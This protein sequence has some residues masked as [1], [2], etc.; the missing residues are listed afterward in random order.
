M[1]TYIYSSLLKKGA[2]KERKAEALFL[3]VCV[4]VLCVCCVYMYTSVSACTWID[5]TLSIYSLP[6]H[7]LLSTIKASV[8]SPHPWK[9]LCTTLPSIC[10]S[11]NASLPRKSC[12]PISSHDPFDHHVS[13]YSPFTPL[14]PYSAYTD[15]VPTVAQLHWSPLLRSGSA[16]STSLFFSHTHFFSCLEICTTTKKENLIDT[17]NSHSRNV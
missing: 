1:R 4:C 14:C 11:A 15:T 16:P 10:P 8:H 3:H 2:K 12:T 9:G 7:K 13:A 17:F 6:V 5:P